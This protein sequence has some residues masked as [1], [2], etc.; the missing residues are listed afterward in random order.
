M[1]T[2]QHRYLLAHRI[3][4]LARASR[5]Q[6]DYHLR[7]QQ[8]A[9]T[10]RVSRTPIRAA[11]ALLQDHGVVTARKNKGFFM[12]I[13]T[14]QLER[15]EIDVPNSAQQELYARIV[16]DRLAGK[17]GETIAKT[18]MSRRYAVS[19]H[20][21]QKT[22]SALMADG[23]MTRGPGQSWMFQPTLENPSALEAS[24]AFR[25]II[26]P[27]GVLMPGFRMHATTLEHLRR[28]HMNLLARPHGEGLPA[29]QLFE[30]DANFHETIAQCSG[31]TFML[32]AIQHQ[33]RLRRLLEFAS[34]TNARRIRE[35]CQEHLRILTAIQDG[36]C[37]RAADLMRQHLDKARIQVK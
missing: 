19:R 36:D 24:Y 30:L 11:L 4:E 29:K 6:V 5:F 2:R 21:L 32:Q 12:R 16:Q 20:V 31:N 28:A 18:E 14:D 9:D 34:Y 33:N 3:L 13:G 23:L 17:L 8:L 27:A 22:L 10:L 25:R 26:E 37:S 1:D 35:W 15:I 7:E